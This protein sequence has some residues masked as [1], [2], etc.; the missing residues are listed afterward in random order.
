VSV[1]KTTMAT[2]MY[3]DTQQCSHEELRAAGSGVKAF[4]TPCP[5]SWV[6]MN[7]RHAEFC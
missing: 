2:S 6:C 1:T 3:E 7:C 4:G 5:Y